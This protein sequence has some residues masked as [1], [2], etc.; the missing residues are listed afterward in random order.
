MAETV[1]PV[2]VR[3]RWRMLW[4]ARALVMVTAMLVCFGLAEL[5][6]A[7]ALHAMTIGRPAHMYVLKQ[8]MGVGVGIVAFVVCAKLDAEIWRRF[9][10]PIMILTLVMMALVL[11][12]HVNSGD[13]SNRFLIGGSLQPS[14]IAKFAVLVWTPMLLVKKGAAVRNFRNG[15]MPFIVVIGAL[16]L[17]AALEPDYSVAATY[18]ILA[19]ILMFVAGARISHF[20]LLG[21]AG[22]ALMAAVVSQSGYLRSRIEG[23][24]GFASD[25]AAVASIN[26]QQHQSL[27][28]V[29]AGGIT[30]VGFGQGNQQRGWLPLAYDDFIASII[31]EELGFVGMAGVTLLFA[32]YGLFGLR[33]ARQARSPYLALLATGLSFITVFTAFVHLGVVIRLLPNTGLTL[34]FISWGRTNLV[35]TLAMTGVLVNIGSVRE[36]VHGNW[37]TNPVGDSAQALSS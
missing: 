37:V 36:R 11:V 4:E 34:P 28:A 25:G 26:H 24:V 31:G 2:P 29:G 23:F 13:D 20:L 9:A 5:Y 18:I 35:I 30:G 16:S 6:S 1:A 17:L 21:I 8:V 7:S 12:P 15:V 33:I 22:L 32:V 19:A 14:E 10:W 3:E 27:V